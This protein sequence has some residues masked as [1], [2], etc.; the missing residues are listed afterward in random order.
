MKLTGRGSRQ[1]GA[2]AIA[3]S[4]WLLAAGD[5]RAQTSTV[6]GKV[7]L[8]DPSTRGEPEQ[9][10]RGFLPRMSNPILPPLKYNPTPWIVIVLEP[11]DTLTPEQQE[12]PKVPVR[13]DMIGESFK[14]PIF[15]TTVGGE[16]AIR[17]SGKDTRRIVAPA[18]PDLLPGDPINPKGD[19]IVKLDKPY[20]LV[21]LTDPD[22]PHLSGRLVA[23][24]LRYH[25]MVDKRGSFTIKD[26]PAGNWTVRVWYENGWLKMKNQSVTV[27]RRGAK[28]SVSLPEVLE[29]E[30]PK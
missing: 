25:S 19:R 14:T 9:R 3:A 20:E 8:P 1:W 24:P 17:N 13:Y 18:K 27:G 23:F 4:A 28:V 2:V 12:P 6:T 15:A 11:K 30:A 21:E 7:T 16:V 26:V 10:N 29:A 22:S 5:A